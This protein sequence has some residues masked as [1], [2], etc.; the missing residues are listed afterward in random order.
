MAYSVIARKWRPQTFDDVIG[1]DPIIKTLKNSID[2]KRIHHSFIFAGLRGTGKTSSARIFAK[3]LNCENGPTSKPCLKCTMCNEITK[4]TDIDVFE[5]DAASNKGVDDIRNLKEI[6]QYSPTRDRYKIFIIDEAHMLSSQ[7]FNALLKTIEEPPSYVIFIL[8]TTEAHKIPTTIRSRCQIFDFRKIAVENISFQLKKI[9]ES[10]EIAIADDALNLIIDASEGSMRDAES[11][12]DQ[13]I[14]YAGK[15]ISEEDVSSV[16]GIANSQVFF[17]LLE[18]IIKDAPAEII[19]ILDELE[20]KNTDFIKF[21]VR[22][23][24][25]F[26]DILHAVIKKDSKFF[27]E[28]LKD[29]NLSREDVIRYLN[30]IIQNERSVKDSFNQRIAVEMMLFKMAFSSHVVPIAKLLSSKKKLNF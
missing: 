30:I 8:A 6:V 1:Q 27:P 12:L 21:T 24:D 4:G 15:D 13:V 11:L 7:A 2:L 3:A 28:N 23:G 17:K 10:D 22:L 20:G 29:I 18:N 25:F 9:C 19:G 16:L 26:K 14:S 5:I